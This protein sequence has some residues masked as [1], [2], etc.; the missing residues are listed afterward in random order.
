MGQRPRLFW[1]IDARLLRFATVVGVLWTA[2]ASFLE[3][4]YT[5]GLQRTRGD[6]WHCG[7]SWSPA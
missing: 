5:V 1:W 7:D 2:M 3:L 4:P 6:V